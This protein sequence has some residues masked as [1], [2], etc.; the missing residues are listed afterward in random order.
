M[1]FTLPNNKM[2]PANH[3]T[4]FVLDHTPYFGISCENV[5]EFEF[6][7]GRTPTYI[8]MAPIS[9]SLW[10]SSIESA[11]EYCRI[12][13]DLFPTG[14]LIRFFA[15]DTVAHILNGWNTSQQSLTHILNGCALIGVPP[16]PPSHRSSTPSPDYT[17]LH[18]LRAAIEGMCEPTEYQIEKLKNDNNKVLNRCRVIC[19]TSARDNESMKRLEEIFLTVLNQQNKLVAGNDSLLPID[20][21]HLV[22]INTFPINIESSVNNHPSK[23]LSSLLTTEVHSIKAPQIPNKLSYLILEH[24]DLASTTVTGIPMKEEQNASSSANYDVEIFHSTLAHTAILKGNASDSAAIRTTKDGLEYETVTLKWC[25]PRGVTGNELQNCTAMHR[26]TPV[27]VNSRPSLCLINFLLSGRSVMLEMPRKAGG[28]ITSHLLAAHGGEIF[29]HTLCT[30]R[31]VLEDPPSISEGCGG[32]VTDYRIPDFG[33]LIKQNTLLPIKTKSSNEI[34]KPTERVKERLNRQTKYWPLT[35]NSTLIFNLKQCIDPLPSLI[36]KEKLTT[37]EE[38]ICKKIIYN[39]ISLETKMEPLHSQNTGQR[40]KG[41]KRE[42]QYKAMWNELETFLKSNLHSDNHRSV[43]Q[44]LL[45][46]H[47]FSFDDDKVGEKVDLDDALNQ[48]DNIGATTKDENSQRASVIRATTDSPMSPPPLSNINTTFGR[49]QSRGNSIYSA[50]RTLFEI[51]A[52]QEKG[53]NRTE[54]SGRLGDSL[55]TKLYPNLKTDD[56]GP[57]DGAMEVE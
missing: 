29:I 34:Q 22:I 7:K 43:Y 21:C 10:T 42:E 50:Q 2:Y 1:P 35:I 20:H 52:G 18:G 45:E 30:A 3:K 57:R 4:V 38:F 46:C 36:V 53:K 55:V 32:R 31:S 12:V 16:S 13:W 28:K 6:L 40:L 41:Q 25:T 54:F 47:K 11:I 17:V 9:K 23:A 26:I 8:P 49:Q 5:I 37:E 39:L 51:F 48:L 19:I 56:R 44:C 27:D 14:K 33:L 15:S 24:Y